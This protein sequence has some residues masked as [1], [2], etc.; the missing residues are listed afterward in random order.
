MTF[1]KLSQI[2]I[3]L[4]GLLSGCGPQ[5]TANS[6]PEMTTDALTEAQNSDGRSYTS[7]SPPSDVQSIKEQISFSES[8]KTFA[9]HVE[10]A[11]VS[12]KESEIKVKIKWSDVKEDLIFLGQM[13][14]TGEKINIELKETSKQRSD[15]EM[16]ANCEGLKC[17]KLNAFLKDQSGNLIG[18]VVKHEN[19]NLT[20][21]EAKPQK[22]TFKSL[23]KEKQFAITQAM[24][25]VLVSL[26]SVEV[27]P[28]RS[29]YKIQSAEG[30]IEGE[31][32][33]I[34][35]GP[36]PTKATG[37][38]ALLGEIELIGNNQGE[39]ETGSELQFR[40]S[41]EIEK[42]KVVSY[43]KM[44]TT[45]SLYLPPPKPKPNQAGAHPFV[46]QIL[47]EENNE[48]IK[49]YIASRLTPKLNLS[50][51]KS[52][53]SGVEEISFYLACE[54]GNKKICG[55]DKQGAD[56]VDAAKSI[57]KILRQN[58]FPA[59]WSLISFMESRF[60]RKALNQLSGALGPWQ[61]IYS[62]AKDPRFKLI[63]DGQDFRTDL[64]ISTEAATT[65]FKLLLR[66]W[67]GDVKMAVISYNMGQGAVARACYKGS[68]NKS[69]CDIAK[70]QKLNEH[71][72]I[73]DLYN[74]NK[75]DFWRLYKLRSFGSVSV[76]AK[77]GQDYILKFLG[78]SLISFHPLQYGYGNP[79]LDLN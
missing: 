5:F 78:E 63:V 18:I 30:S 14:K 3:L 52:Q 66:Y 13:K 39:S 44:D 26:N 75:E 31:L 73:S 7:F 60:E 6:L 12:T 55:A 57:N 54:E 67:N 61:F 15:L 47:N 53:S 72:E 42:V 64:K 71:R 41:N 32:L 46:Q 36:A 8:N 24:N 20:F 43:L 21:V 4:L 68:E 59:I 40:V 51:N 56:R 28:G 37:S 79:A 38:F 25:G 35:S 1:V 17:E 10:R 65:Y 69:N 33:S 76:N 50:R 16:R 48:I 19:R 23:T 2:S 74:L 22:N 62:T 70:N 27:Y 34:E 11:E 29:Y 49:N 45:F 9:K 58:G 77:S